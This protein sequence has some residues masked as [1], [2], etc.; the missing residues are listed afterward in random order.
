MLMAHCRL[1]ARTGALLLLFMCA[2]LAQPFVIRELGASLERDA[3]DLPWLLAGLLVLCSLASS[4]LIA[5]TFRN[6]AVLGILT[7]TSSMSAIY[8]HA[9]QMSSSARS[10]GSIGQTTNLMCVDT[11][12]F[13]LAFQVCHFLWM[14]PLMVLANGAIMAY[15]IG[16]AAWVGLAF[17]LATI[18]LQH[19]I[20]KH[21][22]RVRVRAMALTDERM[23]FVTEVVQGIRVAKMYAWEEAIF[24]QVGLTRRKE[25]FT[26]CTSFFWKLIVREFVLII[27]PALAMTLIFAVKAQE[28]IILSEAVMVLGLLN[29]LRFPL[30]LLGLS[31]ASTQDCLVASRRIGQFLLRKSQE[32]SDEEQRVSEELAVDVEDAVCC[33][34]DGHFQLHVDCWK[35]EKNKR[36]AILGTVGSGKSS[37]LAMLLREMSCSKGSVACKGRI[38]YMGQSPWIQNASLRD[39]VLFG[40]D[41]ST[42]LYEQVLDAA[43]LR[44]D[45]E[46]LRNGDLTDIGEQGI[47]LSGGQ[48]ARVGLARCLYA[49]GSRQCDTVV[50]D[51]PF[52]ALDVITAQVVM[53]GL[54]KMTA[55]CT[56]LCTMSSHTHLLPH[57]Q[58]IAVLQDGRL[59][60]SGPLE[61]MGHHCPSQLNSEPEQARPAPKVVQTTAAT[62]SSPETPKKLM[63]ADETRN[64]APLSTLGKFV[65]GF[66][67]PVCG[68]AILTPI[69]LIF[70][71]GQ[72]CRVAT[73]I[74]LTQWAA[75]EVDFAAPAA[76]FCVLGALLLFRIVSFAA[77]TYRAIRL[78]HNS[79][80]WRLLRAPVPTFF[81][82]TTTGEI[83]NKFS[84]DLEQSD[85]ELPEFFSQFLSNVSQLVVIFALSVIALPY[86]AIAL[87]AISIV[88]FHLARRAGRLFRS[89]KQLEGASRSPIYGSF[90][91]T[92]VGLQTIRAWNMQDRFREQH[93]RRVR[94]N[95]R[96]FFCCK[97]AEIWLQF[98]LEL[99]T[100]VLIGSFSFLA[101]SL[102]S[103]VEGSQVAVALVYAIQLTAMFQRVTH[104]VILIG[105]LLTACGRVQSFELVQQEPGLVA[106]TD[107]DLPSPRGSLDFEKVSMRYRDGDLVLKDVSFSIAAGTR[108]GVCGRSG[109]GKSSIISVLFR[110]VE[111][112]SGRILIDGSNIAS[113]GLHT[114][115]RTLA[116]IPQDPVIFSGTL[117]S[118]LDPFGQIGDD[119]ALLG[120][121]RQVGLAS[122]GGLNSVVAEQGENLSQDVPAAIS[123][124]PGRLMAISSWWT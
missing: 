18:P 74:S 107:K 94:E 108:V 72:A 122:L 42:T 62:A 92:L 23:K 116:I 17:L 4:L 83:C 46:T 44:Q 13:V 88:V 78:L 97:M 109:A 58:Q 36:V 86:F 95:T 63:R 103:S 93:M 112:C 87:V 68:Y 114:L 84:K 102:R 99:L 15:S 56:L 29:T 37:L 10:E 41:L 16:Y 70:L 75:G 32:V 34:G 110:V 43:A 118:N 65:A 115:R 81:D 85:V 117:R 111:P 30:N 106:P 98:R 80:F 73:D 90:S 35:L 120:A 57:F 60:A 31:L 59:V 24:Q 20:A 49:S 48:K 12:K 61:D 26:L 104:L 8:N 119:T 96:H 123:K 54:L 11:E 9:I 105:Q 71:G 100:V 51:C 39:N 121:L 79:M 27:A 3:G 67:G 19:Y 25:C 52:A 33:W 69:A 53:D 6:G 113:M 77:V 7:R 1:F 22:G 2:Q 47:N 55:G 64:S 50:L 14:S 28:E 38:A 101:V 21:G 124:L 66:D 91:E 45:L 40:Q 76:L 82:V 5:E 89:L